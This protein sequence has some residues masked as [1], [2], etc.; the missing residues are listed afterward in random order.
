[1]IYAGVGH[2]Y[3]DGSGKTLTISYV[4]FTNDVEAIKVIFK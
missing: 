2:P 3:L 1:M 4:N